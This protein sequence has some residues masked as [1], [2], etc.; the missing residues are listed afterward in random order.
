MTIFTFSYRLRLVLRGKTPVSEASKSKHVR[1]LC[2]CAAGHPSMKD[3]EGIV[4]YIASGL[5]A[6]PILGATQAGKLKK[7]QD[8]HAPDEGLGGSAVPV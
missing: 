8:S 6:T 2:E 4:V 7:C 5:R 1:E 3:R